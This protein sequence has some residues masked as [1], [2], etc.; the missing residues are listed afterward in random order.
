VVPLLFVGLAA[1]VALIGLGRRGFWLDEALSLATAR[2]L[3]PT[4]RFEGGSM[5][6]YYVL[7]TAW[8][9]V[10]SDLRWLRLLSV[11]AAVGV[12]PIVH[13]LAG[14]LGGRRLA[15]LACGVLSLSWIFTRYAQEARSYALV[16][17]LVTI[18]WWALVRAVTAGPGDASRWWWR[19][20]GIVTILGVLS[21]GLSGLQLLA[22][23]LVLVLAPDSRLWLR[24]IVPL[25]V[26]VLL[27]VA[28]LTTVGAADVANWVPPLSITQ[29]HHL[30]AAF[31]GPTPI[32]QTVLGAAVLAGAGI[33]WRRF[34]TADDLTAWLHAVVLVWAIVP[35]ALLIV[36]SAL[37]PYL[38][39][40]Y[41]IG[42][43]PAM[44]ILVGL[45]L[46]SPALPW[47]RLACTAAVAVTLV[48]GQ[49]SLFHDRGADWGGAA[50]YLTARAEAG[51]HLVVP[52]SP[53]RAPLD[54]AWEDSG[55]P[56]LLPIAP[57]DELGPAR[58]LYS[59]VPNDRLA[60]EML[61][62]GSERV[63]IVDQEGNGLTS[64][65][66]ALLEDP[67]LLRSFRVVETERFDGQ[68]TVLLLLRS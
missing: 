55:P 62:S 41:V 38:I 24:R 20:F 1:A 8:S 64:I 2:D 53:L 17:L 65:R 44:A 13:A 35:P 33:A 56:P 29:L 36:L 27:L 31:T 57:R 51:D 48:A 5:G 26:A 22:Q 43:V 12:I 46:T 4:L 39:P 54:Y 49:V 42:S 40:R 50:A 68:I 63:W 10:S 19:I 52:T 28:A 67:R 7:L 14:T 9:A 3:I 34:H 25:M 32:A 66:A 23:A 18:S 21:H 59:S 58:R 37:R 6:L 60:T 11:M 61:D 45:A 16:L 15:W 30:L 47:R